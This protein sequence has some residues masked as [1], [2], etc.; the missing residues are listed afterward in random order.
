[1]ARV[2]EQVNLEWVARLRLVVLRLG[3]RLR[4]NASAGLT[5]SQLSVLSSLD[6][7]GPLS[8]GDLAAHEGVQP[9]SVTRMAGALEEAGLVRRSGSESDRRSVVVSLTAEGRRALDDL[10]RQRDAWLARRLSGLSPEQVAAL[11]AA[12]PVLEELLG[13]RP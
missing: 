6:L 11:E 7:H 8:L 3:R 9:P 10:R 5:P 4:Q 1:M 2:K 12:L 13:E